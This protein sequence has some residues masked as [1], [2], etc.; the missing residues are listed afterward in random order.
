MCGDALVA[1]QRVEE[2]T[3]KQIPRQMRD[4]YEPLLREGLRVANAAEDQDNNFLV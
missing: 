2:C 4:V 3:R 1:N